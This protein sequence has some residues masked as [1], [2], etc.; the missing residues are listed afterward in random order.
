MWFELLE[1]LEIQSKSIATL[2]RSLRHKCELRHHVTENGVLNEAK[3]VRW[4]KDLDAISS[5]LYKIDQITVLNGLTVN[6]IKKLL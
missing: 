3:M 1:L 2:S 4:N 6:F 5:L